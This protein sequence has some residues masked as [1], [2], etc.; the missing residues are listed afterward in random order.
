MDR[1][2]LPEV[3]NPVLALPAMQ[4]ILALPPRQRAVLAGL[5]AELAHDAANRAEA[6]WTRRKGPMAVY[7]RGVSVYAGHIRRALRPTAHEVA[8]E[9][10]AVRQIGEENRE[11]RTVV[12][13]CAIHIGGQISPSA[14]LGLIRELPE[15]VRR[16]VA[17]LKFRKAEMERQWIAKGTR[18]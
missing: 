4:A 8:A 10:D 16:K 18:S 2:T 7:W 5:L 1:S 6:S 14:G 12:S 9:V 13:Q 17:S 3:R 11:L 15:A